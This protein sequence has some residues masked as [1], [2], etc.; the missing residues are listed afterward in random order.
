VTRR[1]L[2]ADQLGPHFLD[3]PDQ[4]PHLGRPE[5]KGEVRD[6][7]HGR[8]VFV[9]HLEADDDVCDRLVV[10]LRQLGGRTRARQVLDWQPKIGLEEGLRRML[11]S[12]ER[13]GVHV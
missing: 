6:I 7:T 2:F 1:W 12:R 9:C 8:H 11:P 3:D 10:E 4:P 13:E 5:V